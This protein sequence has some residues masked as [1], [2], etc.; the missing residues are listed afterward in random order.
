[1]E[2]FASKMLVSDLR[3]G[4]GAFFILVF[5]DCEVEL[6]RCGARSFQIF[7]RASLVFFRKLGV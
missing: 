6:S 5:G 3:E 7:V 1:M 2:Y 4:T